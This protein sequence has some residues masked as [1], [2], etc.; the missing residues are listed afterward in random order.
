MRISDQVKD[1]VTKTDPSLLI[2]T[3]E[4]HAWERVAMSIVRK[5]NKNIK[6]IGYQH[7]ALFRKQYAINRRLSNKY[8]PD[9]ILTCGEVTRK[10]LSNNP[11]LK[12]IT[13]STLG[14]NRAIKLENFPSYLTSHCTLGLLSLV[15]FTRGI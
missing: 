14:S 8:N 3:F 2:F 5:I 13:V 7:A 10:R 11:F 15:S 12:N 6:C 9:H 4:G 1:I